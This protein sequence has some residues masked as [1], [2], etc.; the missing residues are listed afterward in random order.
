VGL[1]VRGKVRVHALLGL[2]LDHLLAE[3]ALAFE[4]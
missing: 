1:E 2:A 3:L 4:N